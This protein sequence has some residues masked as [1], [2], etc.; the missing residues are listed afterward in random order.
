M[1]ARDHHVD[2]LSQGMELV[3]PFASQRP[4][5]KMLHYSTLYFG[6]IPVNSL[7]MVLD[8]H[9]AKRQTFIKISINTLRVFGGGKLFW[10]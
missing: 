4:T 2:N 7:L 1:L 8:M 9:A 5:L 10:C 3:I 6:P